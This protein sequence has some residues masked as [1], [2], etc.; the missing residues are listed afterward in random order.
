MIKAV[1]QVKEAQWRQFR[2]LAAE[3]G[4]SAQEL[5]GRLVVRELHAWHREQ[6]KK[7]ARSRHFETELKKLNG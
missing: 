4:L 3:R 5:L 6:A 7:L 1:V 2:A